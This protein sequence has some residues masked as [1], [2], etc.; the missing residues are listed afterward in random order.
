MESSGPN[1]V[2]VNRV[3]RDCPIRIREYEFS[4]DLIELSFRDFDVILEMDWLSRHQVVVDCRMKKVTLRT[5]S[6]EEVTF[7][8]ERSN[9]LSNVRSAAIAKT[10]VRKGCEAYLVYVI[11]T[12]KA[13]PSLSDIPTVSDYPD[14]F[15]EEL[16]GLTPQREIEFAIDVVQGATPA[17]IT[18]YRM[19]PV[20]LK[21][22]KLQ[23]QEF[24]GKG[25]IRP[26]VSPWGA[27]VLF[28]KKKDGTLRLCVD[29]RQLNKM[30]V[31][32]KYLLPGIDDLFDQLKGASVFS[33]IDLRS[34]YHQLRIKDTDVHKTTFKTRYGHYEFLVMPFGLTNAPVAFMDL[35]NRVFP[36][37]VDQFV[38]V[39]IDGILVYSKD[40][41]NHDTHLRAV[42]ETLR[43]ELYAKLSKCEF[44]LNE[45]SFLGHLVPE[46]GIQVDPRKIEVIIE[47][48]P[49]RNVTEVRS[50]LGLT[51][52]YRRFV[53]GFSMIAAPMTRLL[54]K[55]VKFEWSEKCQVSFDNLKAFLTEAPVLTQPTY[56]KEYVI[57]SDASL[58]G[59][60]CVLMQEGTVVACASR[61]LKPHAKNHPMH[62]LELTAI[63]FTLK[64]W[65]HY[66]HREKCFSYTDHKSLKYLPSHRELN[67][68]QR[69]WMELIKDYDYVID[70]HPGN[71]NV[72]AD[73]L[74]RR[75]VQT[76]RALNAQ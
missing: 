22:L 34:E 47:W 8:G 10:M 59:L 14:V 2:V 32:N 13:E 55:N 70:Y 49:S 48:K 63:V 16:S 50:F 26:S 41:E 74:S 19:A 7:I 62:D 69:R 25:F 67:L 61:Q 43:K 38:I 68:R 57:F 65:R 66:L 23:L 76:L 42:L 73:T 15:P 54:Q 30:T 56:G 46:E 31:K 6:G 4:G 39:F 64:I 18:L 51:G 75:T 58:N 9:H 17:S 21:E 71:A 44:W 5:S 35:M 36:L 28:V 72:V 3:C 24:L 45:V 53:K 60:G 1:S 27:P 29:Y 37:Y 52:Y 12:K 33:K 40:R 20:E 11:N